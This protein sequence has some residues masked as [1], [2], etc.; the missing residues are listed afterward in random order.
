LS[1]TA[2]ATP[3]LAT[4]LTLFVSGGRPT[5]TTA[6]AGR[7]LERTI[8]R[9]PV[10]VAMRARACP[11]RV[12]SQTFR[13]LQTPART[14]NRRPL[15]GVVV[16]LERAHLA[17]ST[18]DGHP[19]LALSPC[20]YV[21]PQ[22]PH[23]PPRAHN[24]SPSPT[25]ESESFPSLSQSTSHALLIPQ[26]R[27]AFLDRVSDSLLSLSPSSHH[28]RQ[29]IQTP[30]FATRHSRFFHHTRRGLLF[31]S[32]GWGLICTG[33]FRHYSRTHKDRHCSRGRVALRRRRLDCKTLT[34][35]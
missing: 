3:A 30:V 22:A 35:L 15:W 11:A 32:S 12:R 8:R 26:P 29:R 25:R 5:S 18:Q 21:I 13:A 2:A 10:P 9:H 28:Q 7:T 6:S 4:M 31:P 17:R 34:R 33:T 24:T 16:A 14:G 1:P 20:S 27:L 23:P 19:L